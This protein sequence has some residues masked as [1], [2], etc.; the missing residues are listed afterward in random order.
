MWRQ[1]KESQKGVSGWKIN[2]PALESDKQAQW[3]LW[4]SPVGMAGGP[5]IEAALTL[6]YAAQSP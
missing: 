2:L 6:L 4:E 1:A 5:R 3:S